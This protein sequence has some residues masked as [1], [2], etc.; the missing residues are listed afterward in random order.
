MD[1][2]IYDYFG[3]VE[4][5]ATHS[6][7]VLI[8]SD[9]KE[10]SWSEGGSTNQ[11]L[12]G[13]AEC[14]KRIDQMAAEVKAKA[15]LPQELPLRGLGLSL[16]GG[17]EKQSKDELKEG[18]RTKYSQ[19]TQ[20]T[21]VGSDTQGALATALPKGGVVLISGTGSNCQLINPDDSTF[22][23]GGWGHLIGDEGSGYWIAQRAMKIY[24]DYEDN[25]IPSVHDISYVK[26]AINNYFEV[27]NR[28]SILP[29]LYSSFDKGKI[30]GLCQL[31]ADGA[32]QNRDPLC[33]ALF[34]D[35]GRMMAQHILALAPKMDKTLLSMDGGL[36]VVCVGSVF[37]SWQILQ[38]GFDYVMKEIGPK[39]GINEI[40]LMTLKASAAIGA[41]VLG[42]KE[43]K[44]ALPIDY[45][46][47]SQI[48]HTTRYTELQS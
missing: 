13:V 24:F 4:G 8:R 12:I 44:V 15:G 46:S 14:L 18:I 26:H 23:C 40:S 42:A 36:H 22:R 17:D 6:K 1:C 48:L 41:A 45:S 5:G 9:G 29:F 2:D 35:A 39:V 27:K 43:A 37:K 32:I 20:T 31:L 30:A 10:M 34:Y 21:Y 47:F 25:F 38:P 19:L 33:C 11:W 7:M 28:P 3:G 16:S